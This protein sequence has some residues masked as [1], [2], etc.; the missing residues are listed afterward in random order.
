MNA[1]SKRSSV[2]TVPAASQ[3]NGRRDLNANVRILKQGQSIGLTKLQG[4]S[5]EHLSMLESMK[6]FY[7]KRSEMEIEFGRSLEKLARS[8]LAKCDTSGR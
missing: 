7:K 8:H 4:R 1:E 3:G 6:E 5:E 2:A